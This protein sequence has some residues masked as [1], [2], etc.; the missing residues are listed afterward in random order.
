MQN[1]SVLEAEFQTTLLKTAD[2][3]AAISSNPGAA[4]SILKEAVKT[5]QQSI[6]DFYQQ[7][8]DAHQTVFGRSFFVD[9]I[10]NQVAS[11]RFDTLLDQI[12]II[13]VG[14]YGRGE[15]HPHSDVDLMILLPD[16]QSGQYDESIEQFLMLLWDIKLEIGHSVRTVQECI[17]EATKDITIITNITES[18]LLCGS[19]SLFQTMQQATAPAK[20]WD[21]KTFFKAK[22]EEQRARH[23]KF[24][25]SAFKLEP[26]VKESHG[27]LRD[28]QMIGWVAKRHFGAKTLAELVDHGFL[29]ADEF[30]TLAQGEA[31]LWKVRTSL[32]YLANR[33]EDRLLFDFQRD[34]ALEFGYEDGPNNLAIES[35]MQAYYRNVIE[36]ERLNEMLLQL[37]QEAIL[38]SD[39][40]A[41]PEIINTRFQSIHG[42]IS[43]RHNQVF[44]ENPHALLEVFLLLELNQELRGVRAETIRLIRQHKHLINDEFRQSDEAK[45]LFIS[46]ISAPEGV[47]HELRRMNRYG[48][49]AAYIP[50]FNKIVGRMQYDLFHVYTVD[51]HTLSVV[52]NL[53]RFSAAEFLHEY[54][55]CSAV[56]NHLPRPELLYLAGLFHDIAKG[57]GGDHSALGAVDALEF[58]QQHNLPDENCELV[59]WLVQ[60][61]LVMSVTAQ[62]KDISDPNVVN[63]FAAKVKTQTWL[64]YLYLLTVADIR[65]TNP[66]AWNSWKDSLLAELYNKTSVVL[67]LGK[68]TSI[69]INK[70]IR[71]SQ[72]SSLNL[73]ATHGYTPEQTDRI[74]GEF[75]NEYFLRY[76]PDEIARHL[77]MVLEADMQ[78]TPII[79]LE[80]LSERGTLEIA[81][82]NRN[83]DGLFA[84]ITATLEQLGL[85][86]V[87]AFIM[88]SGNDEY[89]LSIF[90]TLIDTTDIGS[91]A[92]RLESIEST[93]KTALSSGQKPVASQRN[94]P[95][96]HKHFTVPTEV[97][98]SQDTIKNRTIV[99]ISSADR[100]GLLARISQAFVETGT[101]VHNAKIATMGERAEDLFDVTDLD[102][103]PITDPEQQQ[104]IID[105][106]IASLN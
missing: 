42:F 84:N 80:P 12:S 72:Q 60:N 93:L 46:I 58:C 65:G 97:N 6:R 31:L 68:Q 15:L 73:L 3:H 36:L 83:V 20:I 51:Q 106:I 28:I 61:H 90:Q 7:Q 69:S 87:D 57:R 100:P 99:E 95:R 56:F 19:T 102:D 67:R 37:M 22:L 32:H 105:K 88:P 5:G 14:G 33:R 91:M 53:R 43:A 25:S 94:I 30:N 78:Q 98:F 13:A 59:S 54:P 75:S 48:I 89:S 4:L 9:Q 101:R 26:N 38:L 1:Q 62:R 70:S 96:S 29:T 85:N 66:S 47:T 77:L 44:I 104:H 23:I 82:F 41:E 64:D 103:Q 63:E 86:I 92:Y 45:E 71:Q 8:H 50:A 34:L 49:L 21:S 79:N 27:G 52:R 55:L 10:I 40:S 74:W 18:R 81:I 39:E 35:F 16:D 24:E 17:D 2:C 11:L 76:T